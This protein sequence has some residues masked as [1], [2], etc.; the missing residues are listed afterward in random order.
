MMI[1]DLSNF[2]ASKDVSFH[3]EGE[4]ESRTLP[5]ESN[6]KVI[7]P[8]RFVGDIFKVDGEYDLNVNIYYTID[9]NCNRCL[10]PTTMEMETLLSEQIIIDKGNINIEEFDE[11]FIYLQ[12]YLLNMDDYIWSQVVI[13][14]PMKILC[15]NNCKGLCPQCGIDLNTQSCNCMD[16]TIDPRLEKL[17]E[18]F[19]KE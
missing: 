15:S 10:K 3:L 19:P 14:L 6:I 1:F 11:E 17:K 16:N 13:S 2:L 8:I 9:T 4:I 5:K 18:L 12:D 7:S